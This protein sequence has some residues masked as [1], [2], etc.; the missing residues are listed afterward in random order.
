MLISDGES[1]VSPAFLERLAEL[2]RRDELAV[3][4][5]LIDVGSSTLESVRRF[6]DRVVSVR[7]L[8]DESTS[9]LFLEFD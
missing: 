3:L 4:T 1:S 9:E 8:T 2:R 6:S 5:V 7:Q